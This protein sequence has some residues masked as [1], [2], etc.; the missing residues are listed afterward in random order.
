VS[1]EYATP[2]HQESPNAVHSN[3]FKEFGPG[4]GGGSS[5]RG[6]LV[7]IFARDCGGLIVS[8]F[9]IHFLVV[10]TYDFWTG[11]VQRAPLVIQRRM[12]TK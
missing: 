9:S 7:S 3:L 4:P 11:H 12:K 1:A 2:D 8:D 6:S 10:T 5:W